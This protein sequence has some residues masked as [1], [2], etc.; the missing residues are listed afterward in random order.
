MKIKIVLTDS[1]KEF[2]RRH[3]LTDED[4]KDF[5]MDMIIEKEREEILAHDTSQYSLTPQESVYDAW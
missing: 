5:I 1:D 4:M 2:A 3:D